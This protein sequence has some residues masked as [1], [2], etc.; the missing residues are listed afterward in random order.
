MNAAPAPATAHF[1]E[2]WLQ[3]EPEMR[4]ATAFCV[5]ADGEGDASVARMRFEAWGALLHEL[6]EALFE[7]PDAGFAGAKRGW[8][9]EELQLIA[10][11]NA[12]HPL[13]EAR[14]SLPESRAA[15]TT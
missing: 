5:R 4:I 14:Q 12:S 8:W 1:V 7:L 10:A 3:R 13:G 11:R 6:R 2:K 9:A 15:A